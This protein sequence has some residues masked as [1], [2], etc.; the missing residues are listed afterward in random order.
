MNMIITDYLAAGSRPWEDLFVSLLNVLSLSLKD[1][2][3]NL[4]KLAKVLSTSTPKKYVL[5]F[6]I[7]SLCYM[8]EKLDAA[9]TIVDFLYSN[10]T[11]MDEEGLQLRV[12]LLHVCILLKKLQL[13][14]VCCHRETAMRHIAN[15]EEVMS[16]LHEK[17]A[18]HDNPMIQHYAQFLIHLYNAYYAVL[19]L[20]FKSAKKEIKNSSGALHK[21]KSS[22]DN[23]FTSHPTSDSV[24]FNASSCDMPP[25]EYHQLVSSY[26][27]VYCMKC[28]VTFMCFVRGLLSMR[29]EITQSA[30]NFSHRINTK[31]CR[32][33]IIS[34]CFAYKWNAHPRRFNSF[35]KLSQCL[36]HLP[37]FY[38]Q[39]RCCMLSI[40][41]DS[42]YYIRMIQRLHCCVFSAS[43]LILDRKHSCGYAW[44]NAA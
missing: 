13:E 24:G 19:S 23:L 22:P 35:S 16:Y 40:I 7:A 11:I 29:I 28:F 31:T 33:S 39:H 20:N 8:C 26:V 4:T 5:L 6:N 14:S 37:V 3:D 2:D 9:L 17:Y 21:L 43:V 27:K 12:V 42:R 15:F 38:H 18:T 34:A 41:T 25:S 36:T 32:I 1:L 30:S 10:I 44:P